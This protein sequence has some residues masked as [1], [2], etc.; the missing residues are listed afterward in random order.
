MAERVT[1]KGNGSQIRFSEI[2]DRET[3][4]K[5]LFDY[6]SRM[7]NV[8][9]LVTYTRIGNLRQYRTERR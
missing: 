1:L 8:K 2:Q 3:L 7:G 9:S 5:Y 6:K 4:K